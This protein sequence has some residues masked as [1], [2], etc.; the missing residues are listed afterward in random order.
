MGRLT[1][2]GGPCLGHPQSQEGCIRTSAPLFLAMWG[3]EASRGQSQ[4]WVGGKLSIH[5]IR[6]LHL[7]LQTGEVGLIPWARAG[8]GLVHLARSSLSIPIS[9]HLHLRERT[10]ISSA[11]FPVCKWALVKRPEELKHLPSLL[12]TSDFS[13]FIPPSVPASGTQKFSGVKSAFLRG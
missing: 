1:S 9:H 12:T 8:Q 7:P 10:M 4:G 2:G 13:F 11:S 6:W 5:Q 3:T